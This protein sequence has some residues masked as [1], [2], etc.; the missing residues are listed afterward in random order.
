MPLNLNRPELEMKQTVIHERRD[1][2]VMR[3]ERPENTVLALKAGDK[4]EE[5]VARSPWHIS[6]PSLLL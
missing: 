4:M 3:T 5:N 2:A 1:R 6:T